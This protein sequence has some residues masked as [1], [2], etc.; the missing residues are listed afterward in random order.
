MSATAAVLALSGTGLVAY[1]LSKQDT[2]TPPSPGRST[3]AAESPSGAAS[4]S[5][6]ARKGAAYAVP[7]GEVLDRS[8]PT[9]VRIP[10]LKVNTDVID[11]GLQPNRRMEVPQNGKQ[12]GWFT[13]SPTPGQLGPSIIAAHV[14]W[15]SKRGV[16]FELG[17]MKPGQRIEVDRQDGSTAAFQVDQVGQYPKASFPTEKVYGTVDRA[18]LRLITCGGVYDGDSGHH[19]DNI[20]VFAHLVPSTAPPA[21]H[22]G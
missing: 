13:G 12:A 15:Q 8:Q 14:T 5:P 10:S 19:L 16:F 17:A 1:G 7:Q 20:V 21:H 6:P 9:R 11:L 3:A 4:S 22:A 2:A 18:E